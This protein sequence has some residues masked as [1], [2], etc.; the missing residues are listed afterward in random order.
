MTSYK[1]NFMLHYLSNKLLGAEFH[2]KIDVNSR[3]SCEFYDHYN[4]SSKT[5]K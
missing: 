2:L 3:Y 5:L 1:S 4:M